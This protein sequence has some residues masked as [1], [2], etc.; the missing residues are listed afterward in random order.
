R[1]ESEQFKAVWV[2]G[3]YREPWIDEATAERLAGVE[4]LIV[5]DM[6]DSPLWRRATY[7]LPG[8]SFAERSGSYVNFA[9]RLQ[10]FDWA[11]RTPAAPGSRGICTGGC[12]G[13]ADC[14]TRAPCSARWP[15]R[16]VISPR[17]EMRF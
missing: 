12:W 5:Q 14:T 3:G 2:A 1:I 11:I 15:P 4:T 10:S 9:D 17:P 8:A 6:F 13:C 16:S 7:Q